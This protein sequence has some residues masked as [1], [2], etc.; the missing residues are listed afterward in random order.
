[1][2]QKHWHRDETTGQFVHE[3]SIL[4]NAPADTCFAIWSQ[5]ENLPRIMKHIERV[6]MTGSNTSHWDARV[7]GVHLEWDAITTALHPTD[8][9]AWTATEGV[10]NS[11]S[12]R[13]VPTPEGCRIIV[14]LMYD[15]PYGILGDLA[16]IARVNDEFYD[17][18]MD[19]LQRFKE[20][21]ESGQ[22]EQYR[23]A[24]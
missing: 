18:L 16:A 11:G 3:A 21:I 15:P 10:Q 2:E 23:K 6:Q 12:V 17:D 20:A 22:T 7:M 9:I 1:M 19:D 14:H 4:V 8:A 5:L 24:A 13:F